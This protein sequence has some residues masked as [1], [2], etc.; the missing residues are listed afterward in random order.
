MKKW[1]APGTIC[2]SAGA[3]QKAAAL[4]GVGH[5]DVRRRSVAPADGGDGQHCNDEQE[6]CSPSHPVRCTYNGRRRFPGY[7]GPRPD[8]GVR[9]HK[10]PGRFIWFVRGSPLPAAALAMQPRAN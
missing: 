2:T 5:A 6:D 1:W 10:Y 7:R 3:H 4:A 9:R 8:I